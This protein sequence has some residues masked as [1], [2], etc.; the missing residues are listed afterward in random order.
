MRAT[1]VIPTFNAR[2]MLAETL[3]A[4]EQQT[5]HHDVVVVDN[6][7]ADGTVE[8]LAERFPDVRVVSLEENLGFGR[9]INRGVELV[10]TDVVVLINNDVVCPPDFLELLLEP[11]SEPRVGMV[12]G[13]LLQ[14]DRPELVDTAGI[15]LDTTLRSW[16]ALWNQPVTELSGAPEPAGPCGGAAAYRTSVFREAG[17]FD[18]AFFAYWEDVDLALRIRLAGHG[19]VRAPE[20]RALH[21]HGQTLGAASPRQRELEAFGRGFVLARYRVARRSLATRAKIAALDWPVLVVHLVIRRETAPIRERHRA[22]GPGSP[23]RVCAPRSSSRSSRSARRSVARQT[24]C[25]SARP[26]RCRRTWTRPSP[27]RRRSGAPRERGPLVDEELGA[28]PAGRALGQPSGGGQRC[29]GRS[30]DSPTA[31]LQQR[32][33]IRPRH[34]RQVGA[35]AMAPLRVAEGAAND[36][37]AQQRPV[38]RVRHR[39]VQESVGR[40]DVAE[41]GQHTTGLAEVL[42]DVVGEDRVER[43]RNGGEYVLDASLDHVVVHLT[44]LLR[45]LRI[46]LDSFQIGRSPPDRTADAAGAA[47]DVE[48]PAEPVRKQRDELRAGLLEVRTRLRCC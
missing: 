41:A 47:P 33:E 5:A 10:E 35:V 8:M 13:V 3:D 28:Q 12:A 26:A 23:A 42:E 39:G 2:G 1:V 19:C 18:E 6:A 14:H 7:S 30:L 34:P 16:D 25:A 31:R 15:E 17:G 4:L 48:H 46:E 32:H 24:C 22:A 29:M 9:A 20:A 43:P 45:G 11:F 37:V 40:G 27:R 38:A 36:Q 44:R 21:K